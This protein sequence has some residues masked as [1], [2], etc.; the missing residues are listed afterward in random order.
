MGRKRAF[1]I[2]IAIFTAASAACATAPSADFLIGARLVQAAGAA[3]ITPASL[4]LLLPSFPPERRHLAIGI[5]AAVGGVGAAAGPPLGGLLVQASWRWVFLVNVPIGLVTLVVG[6]RVLQEIRH[7]ETVRADVAGAALLG[8]SVAALVL[9]IVKAP[10]WGWT[11]ARVIG[12]LAIAVAFGAW[13]V[14]RSATHPAPIVEPELLR[15]RAFA[16]ST[17]ATAL[18]YAAFAVMLLSSVLFL[19]ESWHRGILATG[20]MLTPG[21]AL[22]ATTAVPGARLGA[23]FG[24][25]PVAVAGAILFTLGGVLRLAFLGPHVD[26]VADFL[27]AMVIGGMGVGLV[28]P[29]LTAAASA[30]LPPAR[31]ATGIAVQTTGRQIGSAIGIAV[32]VPVL[33]VAAQHQNFTGAW[34]LMAFAA[35]AAGLTI[36]T[37]GRGGR[38]A[39]ASAPVAAPAATLAVGAATHS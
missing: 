35:A 7:P 2:G 28:L 21:P 19:T 33:G 16:T 4:G 22:A 31:I 34:E 32:L 14:R 17:L 9:A 8:T 24:P 18:F 29:S 15:V 23:R 11:D 36:A 5:W 30:A 37:L 6:W 10:A 20:L 27:P 1:L 25:G 13:L 12:L 3:L 38:Q 26:Y 39:P